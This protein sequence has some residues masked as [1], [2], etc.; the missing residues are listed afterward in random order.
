MKQWRRFLHNEGN[1]RQLIKFFLKQ[2][3][4]EKFILRLS[5]KS[6]I[7]TMENQAFQILT[8]NMEVIPELKSDE[9][10]ADG[11]LLLHAAHAIN[12]NISSIVVVSED[13]DVF[14]LMLAH[15]TK[16][17]GCLYQKLGTRNRS[18]Y[19]DITKVA[20]SLGH[21]SC[22]ALI[23]LHAFTGCDTVSAFAGR[24]KARPLAIMQSNTQF[25]EVFHNLGAEYV[26][27]NRL[28]T[29]LEEYTCHIYGLKGCQ[30]IN[31]LR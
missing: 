23:G 29:K 13:T 14:L 17:D 8:C 18:W 6:F 4:L 25:I 28:F 7:V 12:S 21:N 9:E 10:E 31:E 11:R 19:I 5:G 3:T 24:G 22:S 1:K 27:S 15:A 2:W 30:D 20:T 16:M 26:L